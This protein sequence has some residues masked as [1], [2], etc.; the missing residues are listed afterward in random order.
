MSEALGVCH[1]AE[2]PGNHQLLH[3]Y[4]DGCAELIDP[5]LKNYL[6]QAFGARV[7]WSST[8]TPKLNSIS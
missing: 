1:V 3:Y 8:D 5:K 6:L 2:Y 4:A 7:T